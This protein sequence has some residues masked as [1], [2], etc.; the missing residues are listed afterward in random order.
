[1]EIP[2]RMKINKAVVKVNKVREKWC[3]LPQLM[4]RNISESRLGL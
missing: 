1:M 3:A 4:S 2:R